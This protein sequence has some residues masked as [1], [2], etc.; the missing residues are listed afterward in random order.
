M[1]TD[2]RAVKGATCT[3]D[4]GVV[5]LA[6]DWNGEGGVSYRYRPT[7]VFLLLL[8][9][10]CVG[11]LVYNCVQYHH[12]KLEGNARFVCDRLFRRC[13]NLSVPVACDGVVVLCVW[14]L[15][16]VSQLRLHSLE[17]AG[18]FISGP[19][20]SDMTR[21]VEV[22]QRCSYYSYVLSTLLRHVTSRLSP[23]RPEV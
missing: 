2:R 17:H 10:I 5:V 16:L 19:D 12:T 1:V 18:M 6:D 9:M 8:L 7:W 23:F 14:C 20:G 21:L 4:V 13:R 3:R 11:K 22:S 15:I